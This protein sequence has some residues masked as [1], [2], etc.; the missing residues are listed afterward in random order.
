MLFQEQ[1]RK[2]VSL[3]KKVFEEE[4]K[5]RK[6]RNNFEQIFFFSGKSLRKNAGRKDK[7]L[8]CEK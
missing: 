6:R 3:R 1:N 4:K 7:N 2:K 5:I 8:L